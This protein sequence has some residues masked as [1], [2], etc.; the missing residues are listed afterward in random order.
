MADAFQNDA[1]QLGAFQIDGEILYD[2]FQCGAFQADAFQMPTCDGGGT[3]PTIDLDSW[4]VILRRRI[5][6]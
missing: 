4:L 2:A 3:E 5:G 6:K 1:F